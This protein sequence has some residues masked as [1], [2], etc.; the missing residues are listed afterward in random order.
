MILWSPTSPPSVTQALLPPTIPLM[1][2]L[3]LLLL[4]LAAL[5]S[6]KSQFSKPSPHL[7]QTLI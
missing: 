4:S 2:L 1:L 6:L 3:L 7:F 5:F